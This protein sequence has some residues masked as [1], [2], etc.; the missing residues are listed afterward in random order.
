MFSCPVFSYTW[1]DPPSNYDAKKQDGND[2]KT[3]AEVL[4]RRLKTNGTSHSLHPFILLFSGATTHFTQLNICSS[5]P[6]N[7]LLYYIMSDI[8]Y[9]FG[10]FCTGSHGF[11]IV[12]LMV[13]SS[14][15]IW[16]HPFERV[17]S[18]SIQYRTH[19]TLNC[20][21]KIDKKVM[22]ENLSCCALKKAA[23][24]G[25]WLSS[26]CDDSHGSLTCSPVKLHPSVHPLASLSSL[27]PA[28]WHVSPPNPSCVVE[29]SHAGNLSSQFWACTH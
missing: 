10:V 6:W 26:A 28:H 20:S 13:Y 8:Q 18:I 3:N 15:F 23:V 12:F 11:G 5:T 25:C 2:W 22:I 7:L 19:T 27:P 4:Y 17:I 29:R 16:F 1:L 9:I 14:V 21:V 24:D